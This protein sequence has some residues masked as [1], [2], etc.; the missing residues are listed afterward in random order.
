MHGVPGYVQ[1]LEDALLY[2]VCCIQCD[3]AMGSVD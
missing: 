3:D 1:Y 2:V